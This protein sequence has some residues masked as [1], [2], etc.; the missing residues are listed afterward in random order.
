MHLKDE[1]AENRVLEEMKEGHELY[2]TPPHLTK[3]DETPEGGHRLRL[4]AGVLPST[5]WLVEENLVERIMAAAGEDGLATDPLF[6]KVDDR[7]VR[8]IREFIPEDS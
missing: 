7:N 3:R 5:A 8:R 6:Y 4:S 2:L 1:E